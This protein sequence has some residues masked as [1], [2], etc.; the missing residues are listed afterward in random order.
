MKR[1]EL[2]VGKYTWGAFG[3]AIRR[4]LSIGWA[5]WC[6][7][8]RTDWPMLAYVIHVPGE[9]V[10]LLGSLAF[11][12]LLPRGRDGAE[13][14]EEEE[15]AHKTTSLHFMGKAGDGMRLVCSLGRLHRAPMY[16]LYIYKQAHWPLPNIHQQFLGLGCHGCTQM[17]PDAPRCSR[18]L[19]DAFIYIYI[20]VITWTLA[21]RNMQ[22]VC[23]VWRCSTVS[24]VGAR[25]QCFMC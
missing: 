14:E 25:K 22:C 19:P 3:S 12:W 23:C 10:H 16:N 7:V 18:C 20:Y 15:Q 2:S 24:S 11:F 5:C 21:V 17:P 9:R 8:A 6:I 13:E 1:S 4:Q